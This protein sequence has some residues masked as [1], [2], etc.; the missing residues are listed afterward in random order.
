MAP[1]G[2]EPATFRFVAQQGKYTRLLTVRLFHV[3]RTRPLEMI[4]NLL[5]LLSEATEKWNCEMKHWICCWGFG[6]KPYRNTGN[7]LGD[8][9]N[10]DL[11]EV[12]CYDWK[13]ME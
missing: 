7:I 13:Q 5:W 6:C 3:L 8:N 4:Q 12:G 9:I 2:F 10:M 11:N 1:A